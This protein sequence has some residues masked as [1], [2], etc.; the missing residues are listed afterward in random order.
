MTADLPNMGHA[1]VAE[2]KQKIKFMYREPS[3]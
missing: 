3:R 2:E 1:F